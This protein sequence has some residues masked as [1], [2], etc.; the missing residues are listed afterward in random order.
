MIAAF[1][2]DLKFYETSDGRLYVRG[3][4]RQ[5][6]ERY[7]M[8]FEK[9]YV[10]GR[11][12]AIKENETQGFEIFG[13][14]NL[15]FYEVPSIHSAKS[16]FLNLNKVK[17]RISKLSNIVD[18]VITRQPSFN[19]N[20]IIRLCIKNSIPYIVEI[21]G[22]PWDAL[23]T[24]SLKGKMLAP[25]FEIITRH[26]LRNAGFVIY[27]TNQFL[28][29]RYPTNGKFTNCSN[30]TLPLLDDEVLNR[31]IESI[32]N[33]K[34]QIFHIA[35]VG[36]V[37]VKYKGQQYIIKSLAN[38]KSIGINNYVYHIVGNGNEIPLKSL[39][40]SLGI[41]D[42]IVFHGALKHEEIFR[43]LDDMDLYAQPSDTEGLPRALIEA[44][45]RGLPCFGTNVG[46]IPELLDDSCLFNRNKNRIDE[47]TDII[48]SF[49]KKKMLEQA[50]TNFER[51]K[52]YE[53]GKIDERRKRIFVEFL[54]DARKSKTL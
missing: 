14:Y 25:F 34:G 23:W 24:H 7:L 8:H 40:E 38:L 36:A 50:K 35:T 39:A 52:E 31:R 11:K 47:I 33:K 44:M 5:Y 51:A 17:K 30:V 53:A 41:S 32:K 29:R 54:N 45:S 49:D 19:S 16:L 4:D 9:L 20:E 26:N 1:V 15:L 43:F 48:K 42:K 21:G 13:D 28:Q 46:G 6:W 3:Y 27:V 37:G 22:S 2:N 10:V 18:C 12:T